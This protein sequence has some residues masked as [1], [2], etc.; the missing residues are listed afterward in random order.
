VGEAPRRDPQRDHI[1]EAG[2][3]QTQRQTKQAPAEPGPK[4]AVDFAQLQRIGLMP[5]PAAEKMVSQE[6]QRIK[7]PLLMNTA[8]AGPA[9][10]MGNGNRFMMAS[11]IQGE[12]KTFS[13]LN[14]ALSL[15]RE[16]D[17]SVVLVDGDVIKPSISRALGL[18]DK[19]GLTDILADQS[20][21]FS[22]IVFE[23]NVPRLAVLP[24]GQRN[25][26][27][28]ELL[29]SQRMAWF[30]GELSR[31]PNRLAVFDSPPLLATSEAQALALAVGH[32]LLVVKAGS[33]ER[34][35]VDTALSLVTAPDQQVSLIL[36]QTTKAHGDYYGSYYG[37][38]YDGESASA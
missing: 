19:R 32:V 28:T 18:E 26:E 30:M 13:S 35:A 7:R 6:Y 20:I 2:Q 25:D 5:P 3:R 1:A 15:A 8:G 11:A 12:G 10:G 16:R 21:S 24:A 34:A 33:T 9:A 23:T 38:Y 27:A 22:S 17:C 37:G 36:N 31:D 14:L 4:I 29:A